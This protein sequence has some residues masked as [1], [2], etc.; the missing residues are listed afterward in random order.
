M[1]DTDMQNT[2]RNS[3][4]NAVSRVPQASLSRQ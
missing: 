4:I 2:I 1:L 3:G